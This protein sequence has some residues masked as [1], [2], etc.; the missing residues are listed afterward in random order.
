ML[1]EAGLSL[2]CYPSAA[3][4]KLVQLVTEKRVNPAEVALRHPVMK[5]ILQHHDLDSLHLATRQAIRKAACRV[6]AMQVLLNIR[7]FYFKEE[8]TLH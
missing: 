4:T 8:E 5:F 3:L 7:I 2:L 6:Y 1:S